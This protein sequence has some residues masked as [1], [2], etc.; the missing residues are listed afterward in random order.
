M[1]AV[2]DQ[3]NALGTAIGGIAVNNALAL[4]GGTLNIP[5]LP[6]ALAPFSCP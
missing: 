6:T 5:A 4:L 3:S 1:D 2:T